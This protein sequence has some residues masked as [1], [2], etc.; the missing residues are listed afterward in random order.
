MRIERVKGGTWER[1]EQVLQALRK[2][3][4]AGAISQHMEPARNRSRSFGKL[5]EVLSSLA[6]T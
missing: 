6:A 1:L 3:E 5:R 4:V 2:R